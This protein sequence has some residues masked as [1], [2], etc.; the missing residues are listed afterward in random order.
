MSSLVFTSIDLTK[1][2]RFFEG[3]YSNNREFS[4]IMESVF[5]LLNKLRIFSNLNE[6]Q[7]YVDKYINQQNVE[8]RSLI[9]ALKMYRCGKEFGGSDDV[10]IAD[11]I[12]SQ[13][14]QLESKNHEKTIVVK[15]VA[16]L[17]SACDEREFNR[18]LSSIVMFANETQKFEIVREVLNTY[19][20]LDYRHEK[21]DNI[22]TIQIEGLP[23]PPS[24]PPIEENAR[25]TQ[26]E[27]D[28]RPTQEEEDARP[29]QEE[30]DARPTQ[31]EEDTRPT[32]EERLYDE[33]AGGITYEMNSM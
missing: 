13:L 12:A 29:T 3:V 11:Y 2:M 18:Q 17:T 9:I 30:E 26:E 5:C 4:F 32:Q 28:A 25:P 1:E 23:L 22:V 20:T 10:K 24:P 15:L 8:T 14:S 27:E 19:L 31:E 33:N 21:Y 6:F 16:L 7:N